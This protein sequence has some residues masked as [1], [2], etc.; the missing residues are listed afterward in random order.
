[1]RKRLFGVFAAAMLASAMLAPTAFAAKPTR[2]PFTPPIPAVDTDCGY[3]IGIEVLTSNEV[4]TTFSDGRMVGTGAL[5][6]RVTNL[7]RPEN[8]MVLNISGSTHISADGSRLVSTGAYGG[9]T[10]GGLPFVFFH[11]R[12]VDTFDSSGNVTETINGHLIDVC[13]ALAA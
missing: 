5:K 13:E 9:P 7:D 1:M 3:P 11:G 4:L 2:V 8:T 12:I 6:I 10:P